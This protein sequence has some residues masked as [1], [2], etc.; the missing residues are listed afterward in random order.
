[1]VQ[2]EQ[3]EPCCFAV[4]L[5]WLATPIDV[6]AH[7]HLAIF[8]AYRLYNVEHIRQG[9]RWHGLRLGFFKNPNSAMQVAAYVRSDYPTVAV[10]PVAQKERDEAE[11]N[12]GEVAAQIELSTPK[13]AP[14]GARRARLE[15]FE[16]LED[17]RP[18]PIKRD[19]DEV[20]ATLDESHEIVS[21]AALHR[22]SGSSASNGGR[23]SRLLSRLSG[24]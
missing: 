22:Q 1:M 18:A 8:D 7:P 4:Q 3:G 13:L 19:V 5:L 24:R 9:R 23:L 12:A 10:V 17:D 11:S 2:G 21:A 6:A 14:V 16:L 20:V 15:G